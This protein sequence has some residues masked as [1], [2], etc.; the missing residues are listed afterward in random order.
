[1]RRLLLTEN[2]Y[3]CGGEARRKAVDGRLAADDRLIVVDVDDEASSAGQLGGAPLHAQTAL[4]LR[5]PRH[6]PTQL[7]PRRRRRSVGGVGGRRVGEADTDRGRRP[8]ADDD[9]AQRARPTGDVDQ[10]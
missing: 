5:P 6:P 9:A 10:S 2:G 8:S 3:G 1:M 4:A 7:R